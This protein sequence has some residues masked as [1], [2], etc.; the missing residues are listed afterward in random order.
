[1]KVCKVLIPFKDKVT[2]AKYEEGDEIRL[3]DERIAEIRTVSIN[4]VLVIREAPKPK[5]KKSQ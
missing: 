2:G 1:M 3:S 4:M 5:K